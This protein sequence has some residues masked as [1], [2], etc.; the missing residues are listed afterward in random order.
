VRAAEDFSEAGADELL[1]RIGGPR[2]EIIGFADHR[3]EVGDAAR[4]VVVFG[5]G[6][7]IP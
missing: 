7:G 6:V 1:F 2:V 3:V 4:R 5:I